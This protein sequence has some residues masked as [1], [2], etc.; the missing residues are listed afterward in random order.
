MELLLADSSLANLERVAVSPTGGAPGCPVGS[1][2][3][4][5]AVRRGSAM[6]FESSDALNA[7]PNLRGR[8][9]GPR[10]AVCMPV[11]FMGKALGVLHATS[12]D[13]TLVA[14]EEI[15]R[16]T[17]LAGQA[18]TRLGTMRA[19]R[20]N[21]VQAST[22]S[23]TGLLNRRA[24]EDQTLALTQRNE[25]FAVVVAD[26]DHF[27][28]LNDTFG[29]HAGDRALGVFASA[30]RATVRARDV[31][32]RYGGDEFALVLPGLDAAGALEVTHRLRQALETSSGIGEVP[33]FTASFGV[34]DSS[35]AAT[36]EAILR[37]A[38]GALF[39]AKDQGRDR[40]VVHDPAL[41]HD[42]HPK[43]A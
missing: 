12:V 2:W 19:F 39:R 18:G 4:C 41:T 23:L 25:P 6:H 40:V 10:S 8:P 27:K 5:P 37:A 34:A 36:L 43:A 21:E 16:M 15:E 38:D 35:S 13:G 26:L 30:L 31:A 22:D 24:F 11:T 7:C 1:P 3:S 17:I 9:S 33:S 32:S 29:H 14:P 42:L 28:E 20:R